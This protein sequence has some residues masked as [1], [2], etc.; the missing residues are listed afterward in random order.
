MNAANFM[1]AQFTFEPVSLFWDLLGQQPNVLQSKC[2]N[3]IERTEVFYL[4]E[5]LDFYRTPP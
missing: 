4:M 1:V 5:L 2:D 3:D